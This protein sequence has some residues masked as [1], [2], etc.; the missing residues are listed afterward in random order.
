LKSEPASV[1]SCLAEDSEEKSLKDVI[2]STLLT[3]VHRMCVIIFVIMSIIKVKVIQVGN[4][5]GIT[6]PRE[7]L[8]RMHAEKGDTLMVVEAEGGYVISAYDPE[9]SEELA[10]AREVAK[11]YRHTLRELAK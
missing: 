8:D 4:S 7:M 5:L 1:N 9:I 2:L 6:L 10:L 11:Q 3:R